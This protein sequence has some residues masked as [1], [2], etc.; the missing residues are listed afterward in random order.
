MLYTIRL[1]PR[2]K[3]VQ[4]KRYFRN[5]KSKSKPNC[6]T[7]KQSYINSKLVVLTH[8]YETMSVKASS[9]ATIKFIPR[10]ITAQ[11][12]KVNL[13]HELSTLKNGNS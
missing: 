8:Q 7:Q 12:V 2:D 9:K 6:D 3:S 11:K 10:E 1:A 4:N 5:H 13:L